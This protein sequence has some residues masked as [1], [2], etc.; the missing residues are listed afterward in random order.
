[1]PVSV[2]RF[3]YSAF[4]ILGFAMM[5]PLAINRQRMQA[6][7]QS[8]DPFGV[9]PELSAWLSGASLLFFIGACLSASFLYLALSTGERKSWRPI[10]NGSP[11]CA[12]CDAELPYEPRRCPGC[13][14]QLVW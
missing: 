2:R 1:M 4:A 13:D 8:A 5:L 10:E 14:Q 7:L 3:V 9:D 11:R 12:R 6:V